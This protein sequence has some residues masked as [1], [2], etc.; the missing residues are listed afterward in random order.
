MQRAVR[1]FILDS[2]NPSMVY[3]CLLASERLGG[4][5]VGGLAF[6]PEPIIE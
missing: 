3:F 5:G 6:G 1:A 4:A 2:S